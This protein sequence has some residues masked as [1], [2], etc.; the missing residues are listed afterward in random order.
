MSKILP[1]VKYN[2]GNSCLRLLLDQRSPK[3]EQISSSVC[4]IKYVPVPK[5]NFCTQ[6]TFQGYCVGSSNPSKAK[7]IFYYCRYC[8][9]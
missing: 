4:S 2:M 8:R 3:L 5:T 6:K 1:L 9:K 7:L